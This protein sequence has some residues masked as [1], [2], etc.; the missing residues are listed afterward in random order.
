[1]IE[2]ADRVYVRVLEGLVL[3][4]A[5]P[6]A[7]A[8]VEMI[9][10]ATATLVV[11][12]LLKTVLD[13]AAHLR[14]YF[15][16]REWRDPRVLAIW[17][18]CRDSAAAPRRAALCIAPPTMPPVF[19][20]GAV[21]PT[22]Y[23][24]EQLADS[25]SDEQL[26]AVLLHELAHIQRNDHLVTAWFRPAALVAAAVLFQA[27]VLSWFFQPGSMHFG[28][29]PAKVLLAAS[30]GVLLCLRMLVVRPA[31]YLRE[32]D[33]DDRAVAAGA[34]PLALASALVDTLRLM[35]RTRRVPRVCIYAHQSLVPRTTLVERRV[36]RL[37]SDSPLRARAV[38]AGIRSAVVV[39]LLAAV[40]YSANFHVRSAGSRSSPQGW[41]QI[42]LP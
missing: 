3:I 9:R 42:A 2:L 32:F 34:D 7:C 15:A 21:R 41:A 5:N 27:F 36:R 10:I 19:T 12:A 24:D 14:L 38:S 6:L 8:A 40:L 16:A 17:R 20:T 33:C 23:L 35:R 31:E 29:L 22:V 18:A 25:L 30:A 1:M 4:G 11:A 13:C 39:A 28:S 37:L 26:R